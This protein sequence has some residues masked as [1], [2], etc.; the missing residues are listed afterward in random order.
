MKARF[1]LTWRNEKKSRPKLWN[2][3]KNSLKKM[4]RNFA[5]SENSKGRFRKKIK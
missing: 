2:Y 1:Q 4:M 5:A 3:L